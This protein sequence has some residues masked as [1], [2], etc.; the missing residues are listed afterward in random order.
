MAPVDR[1]V[2]ALSDLGLRGEVCRRLAE[3]LEGVFLW[4]EA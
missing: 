3:L 4:V 2:A 1:T